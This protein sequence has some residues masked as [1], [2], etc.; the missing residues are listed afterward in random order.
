[1]K[2]T[3]ATYGIRNAKFQ[4]YVVFVDHALTVE[5]KQQE[6]IYSKIN[7]TKGSNFHVGVLNLNNQGD[8]V[9][10]TVKVPQDNVGS[11]KLPQLGDVIWVEED[12]RDTSGGVTYIYSTYND[13]PLTLYTASPIPFWGSIPGD[14]GHLR[15]HRDHNR[16]FSPTIDSDFRTKYIRSITGHRFRKFYRGNLTKDKFVVRGDSVFDINKDV[17]QEYIISTGAEIVDGPSLELDQGKYPDPLN[18]PAVREEDRT[19][20]YVETMFE[21]VDRAIDPDHYNTTEEAPVWDPTN[22]EYIL[23]NKNYMSYQPILDKDYL[24]KTSGFERELPAAEEYQ[25]A[26]R[27]NNKLLIQ[28]QYGDGEQLLITLKNQYDAGFTIVHNKDKGQIRIRDHMGQGVLIESD[29][30]RPRVM[31]WTSSKQIIEQG[32]VVG[33][34]EF[35]YIR[36][37]SKFG[38]SLTGYGTKTGLTK[39]DVPNQEFLMVS[40]PDI[41]GE[42]SSRLSAGMSS[43][44]G[45]AS[46]AGI[47]MRNNVDPEESS[48]EYSMYKNGPTLVVSMVQKND[49]VDGSVQRSLFSQSMDGSAVTQASEVRHIS[50]A[51]EHLYQESVTVTNA[52]ATKTTH[53]EKIGSDTIDYVEAITGDN[54]A[55][56]MKTLTALN[57]AKTVFTENVTPPSVTVNVFNPGGLPVADYTMSEATIETLKYNAGG[58]AI[59]KIEQTLE[60][61]NVT[62]IGPGLILPITVGADGGE[63]VITIGNTLAP[64]IINGL[65]LTTTTTGATTSTASAITLTAGTIDM[66][67]A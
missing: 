20:R 67:S 23:N 15:S 43:L 3:D 49:G 13:D 48:Q 8:S 53:M 28:D 5:D 9:V 19:Y 6:G 63:G 17:N 62:R 61:T 60:S 4:A 26:L 29:P 64:V 18:V 16:Q 7:P 22:E 58:E 1:M 27:G 56:S 34:G 14:Y 47:F 37:G 12:R 50:P 41:I 39:N 44:A 51:V 21:P 55:M 42:L 11:F 46:S 59:S 54:T 10:L 25:V 33:S 32:S 66:N 2:L 57:Q 35:T 30:E 65:T 40:T 38:D 24:D 36:N 52:S 45:A 31:S